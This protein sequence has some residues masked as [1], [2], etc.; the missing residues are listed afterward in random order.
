MSK[1]SPNLEPSSSLEP[2]AP[3]STSLRRI[4]PSPSSSVSF[5]HFSLPIRLIGSPSSWILGL[6]DLGFSKLSQSQDTLFAELAESLDLQG[7]PHHFIRLKISPTLI[8]AE[9]TLK[10]NQHPAARKLEVWHLIL[11]TLSSAGALGG[12]IKPKE[13]GAKGKKSKPAAGE[14][15][16]NLFEFS[17]QLSQSLSDAISLLSDEQQSLRMQ[18]EA[19]TKQL[20]E[21]QARIKPLEAQREADAKRALSDAQTIQSLQER[22]R[23]LES[24]PDSALEEEILE[25]LRSHD[26]F[27]SVREISNLLKV[28]E[29]RVEEMLDKMCKSAKIQRV[30]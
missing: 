30:K 17:R 29:S 26:G 24:L 12:E 22:I 9:Y 5:E 15:E 7:R 16:P 14:Q 28:N 13:K 1:E 19:T 6:S 11:L 10:P 27:I 8:D 4:I 21:L 20:R 3:L 18:L 25:W 2:A 23:Q